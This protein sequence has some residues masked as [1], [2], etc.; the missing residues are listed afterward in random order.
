MTPERRERIREVLNHR[1]PDLTVVMENIFDP[2]NISAVLRSCDAVGI[3]SVHVVNS[4][5]PNHLRYEHYSSASAGKWMPIHAYNSAE[6]C[7]STL[8]QQGFRILTTH[9]HEQAT[10]L[11]AVNFLEPVALVFGNEK[12]GVSA[13]MRELAD[14]NMLIPQMGMIRSLNIS[15][16]CAVS[17]FEAMRQKR[18]AG[19]YSSR[20]LSTDA[21][22][23]LLAHWGESRFGDE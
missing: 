14:G 22:A 2:H 6:A 5:E 13:E 16:A 11:Y 3:A 21:R 9:L 12:L 8:R 20:R 23:S 4:M 15:V 1:Q 10:D 19:H 17:I 7:V 18:E